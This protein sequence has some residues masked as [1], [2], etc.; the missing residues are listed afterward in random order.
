[1][2]Q[3]GKISAAIRNNN[4]A[5][6]DGKYDFQRLEIDLVLSVSGVG[7]RIETTLKFGKLPALGSF[8]LI[9]KT[10]G[11]VPGPQEFS[12]FTIAGSISESHF[13]LEIKMKPPYQGEAHMKHEY[14][15]QLTPVLK[16][17]QIIELTV[18]S[19]SSKSG[20]YQPNLAGT[21]W[22]IVE[23]DGA[24]VLETKP[25]F[26][27][28]ASDGKFYANTEGKTRFRVLGK[29]TIKVIAAYNGQYWG[30]G[31]KNWNP[32]TYVYQFGATP[33]QAAGNATS[34]E[35]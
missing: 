20:T 17:G 2:K 24:E 11:E 5:K 18:I 30:S 1:M 32:C 15:H 35:R 23:G 26:S 9:Q 21:G 8:G 6:I 10:V 3:N 27:G 25:S 28:T 13:G 19:A 34:K 12:D 14:S 16:Q 33:M 7:E 22:W 29:G 4:L 31:S